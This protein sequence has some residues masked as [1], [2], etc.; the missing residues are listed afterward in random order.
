M[1]E[2]GRGIQRGHASTASAR[3]TSQRAR[4]ARASRRDPSASALFELPS[5]CRRTGVA[6]HGFA[7]SA[8]TGGITGE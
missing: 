5:G 1:S 6:V 8:G 7:A 4:S 2:G 3:R